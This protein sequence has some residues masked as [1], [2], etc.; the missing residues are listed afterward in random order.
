MFGEM[1]KIPVAIKQPKIK[2]TLTLQNQH[3]KVLIMKGTSSFDAMAFYIYDKK[4][5]IFF[6]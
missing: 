2:K 4:V 3:C 6:P 5:M 1:D